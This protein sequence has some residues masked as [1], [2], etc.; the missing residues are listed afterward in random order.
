MGKLVA[1]TDA[2]ATWASFKFGARPVRCPTAKVTG[3]EVL[4]YNH[5]VGA[6]RS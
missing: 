1:L 5:V 2:L 6:G 4:E 3:N